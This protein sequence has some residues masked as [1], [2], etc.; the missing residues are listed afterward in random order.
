MT[1]AQMM[2]IPFAYSSNGDAFY[3]HDFLTGAEREIA[4]E[5][6]PSPDELIARYKAGANKGHRD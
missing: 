2:D 5:D 6:F 3:E 1:Y 4:L